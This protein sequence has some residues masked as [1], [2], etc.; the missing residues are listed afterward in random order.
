MAKQSLAVQ[1]RMIRNSSSAVRQ[2]SAQRRGV[3]YFGMVLIILGVISFLSVF[4][5]AITEESRNFRGGEEV[6]WVKSGS[7][8]KSQTDTKSLRAF[9]GVCLILI[10]TIIT[11]V[12]REGI[13]ASGVILDPQQARRDSEAWSRMSGGMLKD[14]LDEA[15]I[16][17]SRPG[18]G[19]A[20]PFDEQLRRLEQLKKE[21]LVTEA[22]YAA[23]RKRIVDSLG[24]IA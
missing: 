22:E 13:A 4:V 12:A 17:L 15:G 9:G 24:N 11:G 7:V 5:S 19:N 18:L 8:V 16:D 1:K 3:Y 20:M 10:G 21:G 23:A 6:V 2:I 14:A